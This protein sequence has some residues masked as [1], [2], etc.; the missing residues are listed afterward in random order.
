MLR[1]LILRGAWRKGCRGEAAGSSWLSS[2]F[3]PLPGPHLRELQVHG[4]VCVKMPH[5][6]PESPERQHLFSVT[7][8][9]HVSDGCQGLRATRV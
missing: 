9:L 5:R 7:T 2:S 1:A 4:G 6:S 8:E 3:P